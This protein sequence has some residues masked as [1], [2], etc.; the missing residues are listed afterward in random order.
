MN[1]HLNY[2]GLTDLSN[3][4]WSSVHRVPSDIDIV[5]GIPRSGMLPALN[6][7]LLMNARVV[8]LP[9]F[10]E[11]KIGGKGRSRSAASTLERADDARHVLLVDDSVN[12]GAAMVEAK[13][14]VEEKYPSARVT[15]LT[16]YG[17]RG[18]ERHA[19]IVLEA[20]SFPRVFEWN[21]FHT[22]M[23]GDACLDMDGVL[24]VDP[25][26]EQNDDGARY[27]DFIRTATPLMR[28]SYRIRKIVTSRLE[29]YRAPTAE[30]LDRHGIRYDEL[31]MLDLPT[32][33]DRRR[34]GNHGE[35]KA[36][37]FATD[38][39]AR[40]FVESETAQAVAI[41][42]LSGK[43]CFDMGARQ[44]LYPEALS[45]TSAVAVGRTAA[46]TLAFR[47]RRKS[48]V[49]LDHLRRM[50]AMKSEVPNRFQR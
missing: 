29:K 37:V 20:V 50:L 11:G 4:V 18:A 44:M 7:A 28:P 16:A 33:E 41:S 32:A 40:F 21:L 46:A 22:Q 9:A 10:L 47:A 12:T 42:R 14:L 24:C 2:R 27:L 1:G 45:V 6:I 15:T 25:T 30:W 38:P 36:K 5:V 49:I 19:D 39:L 17:A 3:L 26:S 31:V 13:A 43:P 48:R 34:L 35:F 23:M 8:D